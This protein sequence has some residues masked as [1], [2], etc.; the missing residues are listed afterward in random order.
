MKVKAKVAG[1]A[2]AEGQLGSAH[3]TLSPGR[4]CPCR[5]LPGKGAR[6]QLGVTGM[7]VR[8]GDSGQLFT[9]RGVDPICK[10]V[11]KN[12]SQGFTVRERSHR[13]EWGRETKARGAELEVQV[14]RD[15]GL[16]NMH[17]R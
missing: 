13:E 5:V 3:Q 6:A 12:G 11:K 14:S 1:R 9:H 15:H 4:R 16:D 8:G 7:W 10:H 2:C 17:N